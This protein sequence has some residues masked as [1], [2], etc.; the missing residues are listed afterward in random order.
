MRGFEGILKVSKL[1]ENIGYL[2]WYRRGDY[3]GNESSDEIK[4]VTYKVII[5]MTA[6]VLCRHG[7]KFST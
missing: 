1:E 4:D 6:G 2:F 7:E 5:K 3:Y